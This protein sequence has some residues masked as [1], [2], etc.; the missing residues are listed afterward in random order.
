MPM[1]WALEVL[2]FA[3]LAFV[4]LSEKS[5]VL[6]LRF[7]SKS[8]DHWGFVDQA[9]PNRPIHA[10]WPKRCWPHCRDENHPSF[11]RS[12]RVWEQRMNRFTD[13]KSMNLQDRRFEF[14]DFHG[15]FALDFEI[16]KWQTLEQTSDG[17]QGNSFKGLAEA[18]DLLEA[19]DGTVRTVVDV[20]AN[21]GFS[22]IMVAAR[23]PHSRVI[24][25]EANPVLFRVLQWNIRANNVTENVWPLN[26]AISREGNG[27]CNPADELFSDC[28]TMKV[29]KNH[30]AG[31]VIKSL[32]KDAFDLRSLYILIISHVP[33]RLC[34]VQVCE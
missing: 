7:Y 32:A 5:D 33:Y 17:K 14:R 16:R 12:Q 9:V 23:L 25:I 31:W 6:S 11:E 10:T 28:V 1:A 26:I 21:L 22:S 34:L 13:V 20:G 27:Q 18:A 24:A 3:T 8:G 30:R 19:D 29:S 4:T 15:S 2:S